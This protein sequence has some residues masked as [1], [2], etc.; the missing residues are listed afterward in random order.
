MKKIISSFILLFCLAFSNIAFASI[1]G[2][3]GEKGLPKTGQLTSY[4]DYDDGYY[5]KGLPLSG[6]RFTDN[7][8]GTITDN[9]TGLQWAKDGN[10][11]GCNNGGTLA[12]A[13]AI[14]FCEGLDF[15][16]HT[17]WRLPNV[18]ELQSIA[19]YGRVS[20]A[21]DPLFTNTRSGYYWSSTT[22]ADV[23][24]NAWF[25]SFSYGLVN[26]G[27]KG[28]GYYVRPVRSSQ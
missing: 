9:A 20:P 5:Q 10:G 15:A 27:G 2:G 13:A 28:N 24:V 17:D 8:D 26:S 18:K 4:V 1:W 14:T 12:W 23:T 11:A 22:Y 16:G 25:V 7:S 19:D 3:G 6:D 21:I